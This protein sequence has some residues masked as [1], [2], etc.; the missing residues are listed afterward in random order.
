MPF[1]GY[2]DIQPCHYSH[3]SDCIFQHFQLQKRVKVM[4][5]IGYLDREHYYYSNKFKYIIM[6]FFSGNEDDGFK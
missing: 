5:F 4:L 2:H 3:K 6:T 1:I